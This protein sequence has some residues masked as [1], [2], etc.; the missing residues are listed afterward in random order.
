MGLKLDIADVA[1]IDIDLVSFTVK[2]LTGADYPMW[3]T[4]KNT[5]DEAL[6]VAGIIDQKR[7]EYLKGQK[8]NI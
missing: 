6:E 2:C 7:M 8:L 3:Q 1:A 4:R 5:K